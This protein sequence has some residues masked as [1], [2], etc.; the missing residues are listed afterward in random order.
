MPTI[1]PTQ[2]SVMASTRN[3]RSTSRTGSNRQAD[4][5]FAR[6]LGHADEHDIHDADSADEQADSGDGGE[7]H[8]HHFCGGA[9]RLGDLARVEDVEVVVLIRFQISAKAHAVK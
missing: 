2:E 6:A 5:D 7:K 4:A 1:P 3:C 8:G 9:Q